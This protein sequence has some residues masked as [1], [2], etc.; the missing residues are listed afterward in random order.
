MIPLREQELLREKFAAEMVGQVKIDFFTQKQLS[1]VVPGRQ[2]CEYC[3]PAG[4][5]LRELAS[6]TPSISLRSHMIEEAR[7]EASRYGVSRIPAIVIRDAATWYATFYGFPGGTVFPAFIQTLADVSRGLSL[8]TD[9]SRQRLSQLTEQ[10]RLQMFVTTTC[11]YSPAMA[12]MAYHMAMGSPLIR[13]EVT[14]VSEFPDLAQR[15]NVRAVPLTVI[16]I[17]GVDKATVPGAL[18]E[19]GLIDRILQAAGLELATE[20]QPIGETSPVE[21]VTPGSQQARQMRASGLIIP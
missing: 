7:E 4:V 20:M 18:S 2:E 15:Y 6:L 9:E 12:H 14:E 3:K 21:I 1:I 10:V 8:L 19:S 11:P 17:G 5:M 13:T 16:S